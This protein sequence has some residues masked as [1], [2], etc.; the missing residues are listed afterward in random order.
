MKGT[1]MLVSVQSAWLSKINW[2]Q[3]I[4]FLSMLFTMFGHTI[5]PDVQAA[6]VAGIVQ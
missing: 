2:A 1:T 3:A 5:P 4:A 6:V